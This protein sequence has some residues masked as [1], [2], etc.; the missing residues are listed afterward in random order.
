MRLTAHGHG[1]LRPSL[2]SRITVRVSSSHVRY[3]ARHQSRCSGEPMGKPP[4][5]IA[6]GFGASAAVSLGVSTATACSGGSAAGSG[7]SPTDSGAR[8]PTILSAMKA[9]QASVSRLSPPG[10]PRY[11]ARW[12]THHAYLRSNIRLIRSGVAVIRSTSVVDTRVIRTSSL[13]Q[14]TQYWGDAA[15]AATGERPAASSGIRA[16]D[17]RHRRRPIR[18]SLESLAIGKPASSSCPI[19]PNGDCL[20]RVVFLSLSPLVSPDEFG[21]FS[22][23]KN[24]RD[25][26]T[27][28]Y[29][30]TTH[31]DDRD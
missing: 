27:M 30:N 28:W 24:R 3:S 5:L 19:S 9:T 8:L 17:T 23:C 12:A 26:P 22:D 6:A 14:R 2:P 21:L 18:R 11:S 15:K 10:R 31:E 20:V 13:A 1:T 4:M 7:A 25:R 29:L 16:K